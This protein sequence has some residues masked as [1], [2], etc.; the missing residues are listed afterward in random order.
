MVCN[1]AILDRIFLA[2]N[3]KGLAFRNRDAEKHQPALVNRM[4][5]II[6]QNKLKIGYGAV[7]DQELAGA[8]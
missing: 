4:S 8:I 1:G 5:R 7:A 6:A 3:G 2:Y